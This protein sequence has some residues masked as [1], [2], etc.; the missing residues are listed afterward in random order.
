MAT[1][2]ITKKFIIK[3]NETM[4]RLINA[5]KAP[6]KQRTEKKSYEKGKA[7]LLQHYGH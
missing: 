4:K 5:L 7:L 3:D 2:S 1:S 6:K